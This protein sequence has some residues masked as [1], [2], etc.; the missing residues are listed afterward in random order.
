MYMYIV[1]VCI[2]LFIYL[3]NK[4]LIVIPFSLSLFLFGLPLL[5]FSRPFFE[6]SND[7]IQCLDESFPDLKMSQNHELTQAQWR[8]VRRMVGKPRRC[9]STFFA[10]E[11]HLLAERRKQVR[12][13]QKK[14]HKGTVSD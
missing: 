14:I 10:E 5:F 4:Y 13:L 7:F 12:E 9:S 2:Y 1:L 11:R 6:G 3:Y 8:L